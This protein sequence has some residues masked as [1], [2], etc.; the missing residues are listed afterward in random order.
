MAVGL[1]VLMI[2]ATG[3]VLVYWNELYRAATPEP[4]ISNGPGPRLTDE[5][6]AAA[7]RRLYPSDR[8][9]KISR[10]RNLD[11]AVDVSL[12]RGGKMRRRLFDPRS[13]SDLGDTVPTGF[14]LVSKVLDLH[15]N[16]LAGPTGRKVNGSHLVAAES[17]HE[18]LKYIRRIE[19]DFRIN[20]AECIGMTAMLSGSPLD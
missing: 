3:S 10:M 20:K 5:Q 6:L 14:W 9:V 15:D 16:L 7:A 4:I 11:Q 13:G 18:A 19:R 17:I 12:L 8:V 1:Y 2:S